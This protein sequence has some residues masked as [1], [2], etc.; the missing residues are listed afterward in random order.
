MIQEGVDPTILDKDPS[1]K[2]PVDGPPKVSPPKIQ[3]VKKSKVRKKKLHW[4]ALD[5]S[6]V[7]G[8][9]LWL[10]KDDED[11]DIRLDE[12]EFRKLFED[13]LVSFDLLTSKYSNR[14]PF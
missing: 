10:D 12:V 9:C 2:V 3:I 1:D 8:D 7:S 14:P 13:R 11:E 4:K 6:K 5:A